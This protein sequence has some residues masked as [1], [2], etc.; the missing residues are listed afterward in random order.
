MASRAS[1]TPRAVARRVKQLTALQYQ[2]RIELKE[3]QPLVWHRLVVPENVTLVKL[4]IILQT[5]MGWHGGHLHE[6]VVGRMHYGIPDED[7]PGAEPFVDERRVR[8]NTLVESGA[9]RF[10]FLYD[11]GDGWEHTVKVEDL[12]MPPKEGKRIRCLAGENACPPEDV[13]GAYAYFDFV[14]A[15]RDPTHAEHNSNLQWVGGSFDPSAF[16]LADVNERLSM[17]KA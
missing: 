5:V 2:L 8:L 7:W 14:A 9:R 1:L 3:V 13:G 12:V 17:I 16:D 15:I 10:N 11:F 4:A 6:F